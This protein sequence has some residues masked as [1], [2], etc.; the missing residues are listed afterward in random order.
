MK[1]ATHPD[2]TALG[3]CGSCGKALCKDCLVRLRTGNYCETCAGAPE[4][5]ATRPRRGI[6]WWAMALV[7]LAA[8]LII[9]SVI[10]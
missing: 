5:R 10:R 2:R 3:Y 9:R 1:C 7:L 6:P 4:G 8:L